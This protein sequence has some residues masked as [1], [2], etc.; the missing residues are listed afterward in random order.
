MKIFENEEKWLI[1]VS[2]EPDVI[3]TTLDN[4]RSL[5]QLII[6]VSLFLAFQA[7]RK[8]Y[9]YVKF[10]LTPNQDLLYARS[11]ITDGDS[12]ICR[13]KW[14][15]DARDSRNLTLER[16]WNK[17]LLCVNYYKRHF[18]LF[19]LAK[20]TR[21]NLTP[22]KTCFELLPLPNMVLLICGSSL[23]LVAIFSSFWTIF[24]TLMWIQ[25]F[26]SQ[27]NDNQKL[28]PIHQNLS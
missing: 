14:R 5:R 15:T 28:K 21:N 8:C 24:K 16:A 2:E 9:K 20:N 22:T 7:I 11:G 12:G 13:I 25:T 3:S 17:S 19:H 18:Q 4:R 6:G 26:I 27:P 1:N 10:R 23:T